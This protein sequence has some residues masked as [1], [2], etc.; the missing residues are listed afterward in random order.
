MGLKYVISSVCHVLYVLSRLEGPWLLFCMKFK[1]GRNGIAVFSQE[2]WMSVVYERT[3]RKEKE[4][5][6]GLN[7]TQLSASM[8]SRFQLLKYL[9]HNNTVPS[10]VQQFLFFP[11]HLPFQNMF[12]PQPAKALTLY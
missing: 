11:F 6:Y 7:G 2:S 10:T 9:L 1:S 3:E 4:L 8:A 12:R 5:E